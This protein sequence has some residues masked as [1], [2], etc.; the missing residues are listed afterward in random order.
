MSD[1]DNHDNDNSDNK[2]HYY[3][4]HVIENHDSKSDHG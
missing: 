2:N 1:Y 4:D 3:L